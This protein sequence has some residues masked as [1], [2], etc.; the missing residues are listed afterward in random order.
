MTAVV[1]QPAAFLQRL[2]VLTPYL[3]VREGLV[4]GTETTSKV[5]LSSERLPLTQG[6]LGAT[7]S[8]WKLGL[9][10]E[11]DLANVNTF[12]FLIGFHP[13]ADSR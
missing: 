11:Y 12:T 1:L 8:V 4:V 9:A 7:C 6:F 13:G 3:G 10:A 5:N 2:A